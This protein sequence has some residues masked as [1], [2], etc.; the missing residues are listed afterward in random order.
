M[1]K[2]LKEYI[3]TKLLTKTGAINVA[4]IRRDKFPISDIGKQILLETEFLNIYPDIT[5]GQRIRAIQEDLLELKYCSCGKLAQLFSHTCGNKECKNK[6]ISDCKNTFLTANILENNDDTI[7]KQKFIELEKEN[8]VQDVR[9]EILEFVKNILTK[10][11]GHLNIERISQL[12][13]TNLDIF[14]KICILTYFCANHNINLYNRLKFIILDKNELSFCSCGKLNKLS[15]DLDKLFTPSCGNP[16]CYYKLVSIGNLNKADDITLIKAKNLITNKSEYWNILQEFLDNLKYYIPIE[17]TEFRKYILDVYHNAGECDYNILGTNRAYCQFKTNN[18]IIK[19]LV[20]Y[21]SFIKATIDTLNINERLYYIINNIQDIVC[22]KH[23]KTTNIE[24]ISIKNGYRKYCR[25]CYPL[26]Y[27]E[28][29]GENELYEYIKKLNILD[30]KRGSRSII[31]P[32]ELD[33]VIPSKKL[34]IEYNGNYWHSER[35]GTINDYHLNKTN[36]CKEIDYQLI[37]IFEDEWLLQSKIVKARL[38][39]RLGLTKYAIYA[40][41]CEIKEID[42]NIK[43]KFLEKYHIQGQDLSSI[44]L[45]LFYKNRL[46]AVMTFGKRRFDDKEGFELIRYCTIANFNIVGGA[47]KLLAYFRNSY[48]KENLPIISYADKRWSTGNLYKQLGFTLLH[49]S[50][51]NY[52]YIHP[53]NLLKR[54]SRITFQK[55][56]LHAILE[57]FDPLLSE[58]ENMKNN[59]YSRI[60]DCG[61]YVFELK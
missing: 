6:A 11:N 25:D 40:R 44:K 52:Y 12:N 53:S 24:F 4:I 49:E 47:G 7:N 29:S 28:S 48:N 43:N 33:I 55:H 61:N 20:F 5:M 14:S 46:V 37:H 1:N 36:R 10:S 30:I 8:K 51:P 35:N 39:A 23:C 21:T 54:Y 16:K 58:A 9:T 41:K 3:N 59:G 60:Y 19:S 13:K 38:K 27:N 22:C 17:Y 50:G 15:G 57:K 26:F 31:A 34:A 2:E 18:D 42:N 56:K 45:G 32:L